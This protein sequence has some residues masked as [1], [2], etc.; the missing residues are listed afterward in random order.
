[1]FNYLFELLIGNNTSQQV[2][3]L[4]YEWNYIEFWVVRMIIRLEE[5]TERQNE[6][7]VSKVIMDFLRCEECFVG[8]PNY[9]WYVKATELNKL[10]VLKAFH[11]GVMKWNE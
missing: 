6:T 9:E 5:I 1:M 3:K 11:L 2:Q 4:K 10:N 7:I 8:M